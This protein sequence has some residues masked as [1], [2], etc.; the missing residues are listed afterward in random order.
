M[1][2]TIVHS[3]RK[4]VL[5]INKLLIIAVTLAAYVFVLFEYY[6]EVLFYYKGNY[7]I[8]FLYLIILLLFAGSYG[9]FRIGILRLYEIVCSYILAIFI[10]NLITY[11][12]LSLIAKTMLNPIPLGILA[13]FQCVIS[14]ILYLAA[15][16][17]YFKLYPA[18]DCIVIYSA[19]DKDK[20]I[21]KKFKSI[22]ERYKIC[23]I[24]K[25]SEEY[26][27]LI[28]KIDK[29]SAV[30][31]GDI[32]E[33]LRVKLISYCFEKDKRLYIVPTMQYI[34]M[35][36]AHEIQ[37]K[38][39]L[40]YMCKNR[41]FALEQLA[42]KRFM[43]IALSFI[44]II[45]LSPIMILTILAIK[46]QDGGQIFYKQKRLTRNGRT[47]T[48]IKFRSMIESA[49]PDG[50]ARFADINDSRITKIGKFIRA[51]RIDEIPQLFNILTGDMS[52]VGPR[53]ERPEI[54]EEYCKVFPQFRYRLKVKAGLTGYAQIYGK[55]TTSLEDKVKM[56]L[57]YI[58]HCSII[59]D[60]RLL[61]STLKVVFM[62]KS[63]EG[64]SKED[65]KLVGNVTKNIKV[66]TKKK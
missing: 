57:L 1:F 49:E 45:I 50:E 23:A 3:F 8:V 54:F 24:Y 9:C 66:K 62:K 42:I 61:I 43:D 19:S 29:H 47:F 59:M 53:P 7:I 38:D 25:E 6:N 4:A 44:G 32:A 18:R 55:Y 28:S 56:D 37:I 35:N 14:C 27:Y 12:V 2:K 60:V 13:I 58:E 10:T 30:I 63:T 51:T 46:L 64:F 31:L 36:N 22:K 17:I 52:L 34:L 5:F 33:E 39:S 21:V 41:G 11:F 20:A 65:L 16:K 48:L 26:E 40:I 15:N